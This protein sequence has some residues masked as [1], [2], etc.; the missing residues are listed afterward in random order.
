LLQQISLPNIN[1]EEK[2][3]KR[4]KILFDFKILVMLAEIGNKNLSEY[5]QAIEPWEEEGMKLLAEQN[6]YPKSVCLVS[7][8]EHTIV[9]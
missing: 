9:E 3:K 1:L 8:S 7:Q 6:C 2:E 5:E 4:E